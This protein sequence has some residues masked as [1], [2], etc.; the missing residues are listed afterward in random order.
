MT[1]S[2]S[3][4]AADT[5]V[6]PPSTPTTPPGRP[7]GLGRLLGLVF[8]ATTVMYALFNGISAVVLPAQVEA[9]DPASKVGNLALVTTVAAIAR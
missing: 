3:P 2:S 5:A 9:I 1:E 4:A 8:P 7:I 6:A